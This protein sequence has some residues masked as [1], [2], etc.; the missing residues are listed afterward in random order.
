[1]R[2]AI[3]A[4]T[5]EISLRGIALPVGGIKEKVLAGPARRYQDRAAARAHCP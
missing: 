4:M 1:M 2:H 3:C 5:G